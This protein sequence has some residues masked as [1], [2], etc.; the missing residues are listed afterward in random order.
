M[1]S[2]S[3]LGYTPSTLT[4]VR[5]FRSMSRKTFE[6]KASKSKLYIAADARFRD[7]VKEGT[8]PDALTLQGSIYAEYGDERRALIMFKRAVQAW[9]KTN[10]G[11]KSADGQEGSKSGFAGKAHEA[12]AAA[13]SPDIKRSENSD[14]GATVEEEKEYVLPEPR[15]PRWEWE[16]SCLLGQADALRNQGDIKHA[17]QLYRVAALEL[18]NPRAFFQLASLMGGPRDS[19]M[20]RAYLLKAA[21]S[22]EPEACREMGELEKLAAAKQDVSERRRTEHSLLSKEWF[23]LAAGEELSS[24]RPN[25]A[26]DG[27]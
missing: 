25:D 4:L 10:P 2:A 13:T 24:V 1:R 19:L 22:G 6:D 11:A 23:R 12:S 26:D 17:E 18:D 16:V 15:E 20:R 27:S 3:E 5:I 7:I 21:V 8:D 9:E 14:S